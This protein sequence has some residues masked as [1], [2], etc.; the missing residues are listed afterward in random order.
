MRLAT[1]LTVACTVTQQTH[2]GRRT[3]P[4][5]A[6]RQEAAPA[7]VGAASLFLVFVAGDPGRPA[8]SVHAAH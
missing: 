1:S 7:M 8:R 6:K 4:R 2:L 3:P 5:S